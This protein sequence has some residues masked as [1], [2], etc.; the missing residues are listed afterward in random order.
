M[1]SIL[2][3][4]IIILLTVLSNHVYARD[5]NKKVETVEFHVSGAC[6]MCKDRIENAALI[7]GVKLTEWDKT[8][9]MLKVIYNPKKVEE[10]E[11]RAAG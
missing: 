7:K 4:I 9:K 5:K 2:K 3:S 10:L 11:R 6:G 1:K 8:T